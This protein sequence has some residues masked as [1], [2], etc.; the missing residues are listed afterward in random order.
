[1]KG[2]ISAGGLGSRL[3]PLTCATNKR[4]HKNKT[5]NSLSIKETSIPGLLI[6]EKL[7]NKDKRGFFKEVVRLNELKEATGLKF[8]IKQWN[9]SFSLPKVIRALHAEDWNKLV[10]S[11]TGKIFVAIADIR[12]ESKTFGKVETF[13]F[14]ET[15]PRALFIPKGLANSICVIGTKPVHYFYLVDKYYDGS[16]ATAI[17]WDDPDLN[18]KW[19]IKNPIISERDKNNPK[20]REAFP[21]KFNN[22]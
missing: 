8:D 16:D 2:I 10:Y 9:H 13:I 1:M 14:N 11:I 4:L 20:L 12:P 3:Y 5:E 15:K 21:E 17:A 6:I 7:T 19:P 22:K 18:I